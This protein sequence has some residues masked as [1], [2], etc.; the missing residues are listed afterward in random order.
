MKPDLEG[1]ARALH[2]AER[3]GVPI[4]PISTTWPA[5]TVGDAYA[6]QSLNAARRERSGW[7][8]A[9]HKIGL[10]AKPM[11]EMLG[12]HEP[13]YGRV[14]REAVLPSGAVLDCSELIAPRAEPEI[15][16][17]LARDLA[18]PG[19]T[20]EDVLA[21]SACVLPS[22]EVIDSRIADWRIALVDTVADNASCARVV[23]GE[24]RTPVTAVDLAAAKVALRLDGEEVQAGEGR[25]V[26]GHPAEAVAWLA[27]AVAGFG[28]RLEAGQVIMPGS[29]TAAVPIRPGSRVEADF[30]EL[31][32]VTL[33]CR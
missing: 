17:E 20:A 30:G 11:Q 8:L 10:T 6:I 12:V 26:L 16:F 23:L 27:N 7:E 9:G 5:L 1:V 19:V 21:A 22:L 29:L 4:E 31:G 3:D 25:A 13:D 2:V 32:S 15:A 24:R 14:F 28:V 33:E 18:G